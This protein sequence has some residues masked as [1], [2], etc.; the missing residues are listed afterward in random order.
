MT[1]TNR[2]NEAVWNDKQSRWSIKV[3]RN[4]I[5]K[6]FYSSVSGKK[7]KIDCEKKADAWLENALGG[8]NL[9]VSELYEGFI[10]D[11]KL[12]DKSYGQYQSIGRSRILPIIGK[13]RIGSITEQDLQ[14]VIHSASKDGLSKKTLRNIRGCIF[15]FFKYCR[16][17]KCTNL[18]PEDLEIRR[19]APTYEKRT[20]QPAEI[21]KIFSSDMTTYKGREIEDRYIYLYRFGICTGLRPS[22]LLGLQWKDISGDTITVHRGINKEGKITSGKNENARRTFKLSS[23][24]QDA[25]ALQKK[26]LREEHVVSIWVFPWRD[27]GYT[28]HNNLYKAWKRYAEHNG[29]TPVSL[30]EMS[31]HTFV[32]INK[33]M[34]IELLKTVVGHSTTMSTTETYGHLLEGELELAQAYQD[35]V[36]TDILEDTFEDT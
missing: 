16:K 6:S 19:T 5:R 2:K 21:K 31:R 4:G 35:K 34:P 24:A 9:K 14:N 11:M 17:R 33:H 3:Q 10:D 30:Y 29:I 15:A 36:M 26:Q 27:G 25:L 28:S 7:G 18:I 32:S 13:R 1:K 20:L 23:Q 8:E 12:L 22:E